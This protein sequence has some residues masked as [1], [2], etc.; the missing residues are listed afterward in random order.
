[1][2]WQVAPFEEWGSFVYDM[3]GDDLGIEGNRDGHEF[4]QDVIGVLN[5][6]KPFVRKGMAVLDCFTGGGTTGVAARA[7]G[8]SVYI[9]TDSAA[10]AVATTKARLGA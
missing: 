3:I 10:T 9:G 6:M 2:I 4:G 7:L 5:L 1:M 8:A